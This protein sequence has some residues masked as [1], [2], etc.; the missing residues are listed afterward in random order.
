MQQHEIIIIGAGPTG[1]MAAYELAKRG[2]KSIILEARDRIGGRVHTL[3]DGTELGAE[4]IHGKLPITLGLLEEA[5]LTHT[6]AAGE[7]VQ[8]RGGAASEPFETEHWPRLMRELKLLETD[9][10]LQDFLT[11]HFPESQYAALKDQAI[12]YAEGY[13]TA[14]ASRV[15][16]KALYEEWSAEQEA[17]SR[18]DGGYIKLMD[19]LARRVKEVGSEVLL[20]HPV[21]AISVAHDG[22]MITAADKRMHAKQAIVALPLGVLQADGAIHMTSP[23]WPAYKDALDALGFG[24][25]VKLVLRFHEPFWESQYPGLGFLLTSAPVPTWW[26][27]QPN[28]SAVLTGWLPGRSARTRT[29]MSQSQLLELALASLGQILNTTPQALESLLAEAHIANWSKD[30][31]TRGSYAYATVGS[32]KARSVLNGSMDRFLHFAGEYMYTGP[33]MGTVEA[34]FWSGQNAAALLSKKPHNT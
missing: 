13:D 23:S 3:T 15:S 18:V 16:A 34:A 29:A 20:R 6:S 4:F 9:M 17:Q 19:F 7:W 10:S 24:D 12:A 5:N 14:D 21:S 31:Y 22:V 8:L 33:A 26:T 1:L 11:R 32:E 2:Q 25:I 28:P 27:Q 30:V